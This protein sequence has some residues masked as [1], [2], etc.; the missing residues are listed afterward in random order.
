MSDEIVRCPYCVLGS[1]FR[2]MFRQSRDWFVC[3]SCGHLATHDNP[4]LKCPCARCDEM[5]RLANRRRTAAGVS[6]RPA[7][8]LPAGA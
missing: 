5:T 7:T 1:E 6:N 4:Y 2:P 3:V 8:D